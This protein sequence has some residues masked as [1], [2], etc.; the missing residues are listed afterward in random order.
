MVDSGDLAEQ[1]TSATMAAVY[2][3]NSNG[4]SL[5]ERASTPSSPTETP[6]PRRR[7]RTISGS[8]ERHLLS[9]K[10]GKRIYTKGRPPW[11]D[12]AGNSKQPFLIGI[13]GGSASGKTTV[14]EL[15]VEQLDLPWVTILSMDSFYKV[16][17]PEEHE[18]AARSEYNFDHPDA[19]DF[20]LLL[21]CLKRLKEGKSVEVPVYSF[22][23]HSREKTGKMMYG[24]DILIFEGILAF[25]KEEI[26]KMMDLTIFVDTDA[27]TRLCRRLK[28]DIEERGRDINGVLD[29]Y[30]RFVKPAFDRFIAVDM[31]KADLLLPRGGDNSNGVGLLY[32]QIQSELSKRGYDRDHVQRMHMVKPENTLPPTVTPLP[33]NSQVK[34]LLTFI[35]D[36]DTDRDRFI[37]HADR[38]F[39]ILFTETLNHMPY[40]STQIELEN[41]E[42]IEGRRRATAVCGVAIMRAGETMEQSLKQEVKDCKMGQLLI[43]TNR[44]SGTPELFHFRLPAEIKN[45]HH[46]V[47]M[48]VNICTGG[49]A[50]MAIRVLLDHEVPEENIVLVSLLMSEQGI[51]NIAYA[52][53]K[54]RL[55]VAEVDPILNEQGFLQPGMGNF[56][57]RYY[58]TGYDEDDEG[59]D[60]IFADDGSD[61]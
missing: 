32:N 12:P 8:R 24:A 57:D 21:S 4:S 50:V 20:D 5:N 18:L 48:D 53:P 61:S 42:I 59:M 26:F 9:T 40:E 28:R 19:F 52:Y 46:I 30:L 45:D 43:Q 47:L 36:R 15:I 6:S 17:S 14:A 2:I 33:P 1:P 56:G 29:Q 39:R 35:R 27:D 55:V 13:C 7:L 31:K 16:L 22:V 38:L 41:G 11:Y 25:H 10:E 23:T 34:G 44:E 60:E 37:F 3:D 49:A 51:A 58:G 54:V